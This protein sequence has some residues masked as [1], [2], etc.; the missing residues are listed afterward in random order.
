MKLGVF[1]ALYQQ[2]PFED[3]LDKLASMG[4]EAV[5]LGTGNYP[6]S[7]HCNPEELLDSEEKLKTFQAAIEK[8]G[9]MISSLSCHGNP[10]HP[11]KETA[12][13]AHNVWRNTVL[14]AERLNVPVVNVF[15]GCPGDC[16]S[17]KNP[18]WVTCAWPPEYL[19]VL[20]WQW[21]EVAIPYWQEEADFAKA[22]GVKIAFE[23]HPGFLVYNPET[24]LKLRDRAGETI[25]ANFDPSHLIWQG[26]DPVA[27]IKKLGRE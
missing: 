3:M 4:V 2:L 25:G 18:N 23:M 26:I 10:L 5:E 17:A 16:E 14:L 9:L 22:H 12:R 6:G 20:K 19:E 27:A 13:A 1:T 15:S 24:L 8:R 11:N 21:E 7:H